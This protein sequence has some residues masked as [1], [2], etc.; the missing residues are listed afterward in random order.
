MQQDLFAIKMI[1]SSSSTQSAEGHAYLY[2]ICGS[3][4]MLER[5]AIILILHYFSISILFLFSHTSFEIIIL[6]DI[7]VPLFFFG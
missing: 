4:A 6:G 5:V 7:G 2:V 1:I 3:S